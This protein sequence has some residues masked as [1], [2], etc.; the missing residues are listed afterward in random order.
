MW[1]CTPSF[2]KARETPNGSLLRVESSDRINLLKANNGSSFP[3]FMLIVALDHR[4]TLLQ[5]QE[6]I[7]FASS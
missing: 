6:H 5:S 2:P 4:H 7:L 1:S 3:P